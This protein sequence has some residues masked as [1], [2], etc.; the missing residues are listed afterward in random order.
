MLLESVTAL[1]SQFDVTVA[2]PGAGPLV[3]ELERLDV[4][5][6]LCRMPV[7]RY[8]A[9]RPRGAAKLLADAVLGLV[10]ALRLLRRYGSAGVYVSTLTLPSWSLL[11]RLMGRRSVC[12]V[13]EAEPSAPRILRRGLAL[14]PALSDRVIANSQFTLDV[15]ADVAPSAGRRT[16]VVLNAVCG[17]ADVAPAARADLTG[18][19]QLLY[20]G[21]LSPRKG[22]QVAVAALRELVDRG[23]DARLTLL[24]SVFEGYEWFE[25]ELRSAVVAAG[26]DERVRFLGFQ[27]DVWPHLADA[28]VVLIPSVQAEPFGNT[29]V[30]AVLAARPLVVSDHSG[31]REAAAGYA[32]VQA[33]DPAQPADWADAV[34]RVADDWAK[35]RAVALEDAREATSRHAPARYRAELV[36]QMYPLT[37]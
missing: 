1:V 31:L 34:E 21:R 2:L 19:L 7:L 3:S 30:E 18:P 8:G 22:P 23:V 26:L 12:H 6:V 15:L 9:L 32:C 4:R 33:V 29:A 27:P 11:A 5:V 28:D 25:A 16:S 17:P 20:V 36:A 35:Y 10:P 13:H 14:G 24:G 37:R